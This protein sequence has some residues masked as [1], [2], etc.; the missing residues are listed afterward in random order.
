MQHIEMSDKFDEER[1]RFY[2]AEILCGL[3]YLH[4][5]GVVYRSVCVWYSLKRRSGL[6]PVL[7][8]GETTIP[9][10]STFVV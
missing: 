7:Y 4:G 3:Q 5:R 1:T 2:A 9:L 10:L 6:T 8:R